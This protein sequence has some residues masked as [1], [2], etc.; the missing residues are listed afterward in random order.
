LA[1]SGQAPARHG[2]RERRVEFI[3]GHFFYPEYIEGCGT[4]SQKVPKRNGKAFLRAAMLGKS[5][6]ESQISCTLSAMLP[7]TYDPQGTEDPTSLLMELRRVSR[8]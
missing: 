3:F 6:W 2:A 4:F 8:I 7:K 1:G 5:F